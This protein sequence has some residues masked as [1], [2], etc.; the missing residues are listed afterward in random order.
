MSYVIVS[1]APAQAS[2]G[3]K[4]AARIRLMRAK[5]DKGEGRERG[6]EGIKF[7]WH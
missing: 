7:L 6:L 2:R 4:R 1:L 5:Q 3:C